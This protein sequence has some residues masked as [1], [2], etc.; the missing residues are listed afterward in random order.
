M[1]TNKLCKACGNGDVALVE[2]L[3]ESGATPNFASC[4]NG[5]RYPL[6]YAA[7]RGDVEIVKL[8]LQNEAAVDPQE[9][10]NAWTPLMVAALKSVNS[11][12]HATVILTLIQAG[13]DVEI[14][15]EK[16]NTVVHILASLGQTELLK[17]LLEE[18]PSLDLIGPGFGY[19]TP[20]H[21]AA[22]AGHA[23]TVEFLLQQ[24]AD[25]RG[26]DATGWTPLHWACRKGN[27]QGDKDSVSAGEAAEFKRRRL[28]GNRRVFLRWALASMI[29]FLSVYDYASRVNLAALGAAVAHKTQS[30]GPILFAAVVLA[31]ASVVLPSVALWICCFSHL[32]N[33]WAWAGWKAAGVVR[34][35]ANSAKRDE[36]EDVSQGVLALSELRVLRKLAELRRLACSSSSSL[37]ARLAIGGVVLPLAAFVSSLVVC[38]QVTAVL[39]AATLVIVIMCAY[40]SF[41]LLATKSLLGF[42]GGLLHLL[43]TLTYGSALK[44]V[45]TSRREKNIELD[46]K[47]AFPSSCP[48]GEEQ[49]LQ[50][51]RRQTEDLHASN[52]PNPS[53]LPPPSECHQGLQII[54]EDAAAGE[55]GSLSRE[56]A[57]RVV[58]DDEAAAPQ[59]EGTPR[60]KGNAHVKPHCSVSIAPSYRKATYS[61]SVPRAL[62]PCIC[63]SGAIRLHHQHIRSSR[64]RNR[65][66]TDYEKEDDVQSSSDFC[67]KSDD[68]R[69]GHTKKQAGLSAAGSGWRFHGSSAG[70][71]ADSVRPTVAGHTASAEICEE[72]KRKYW[73]SGLEA[74]SIV[75]LSSKEDSAG[76]GLPSDG[77]A[78]SSDEYGL[79]SFAYGGWPRHAG[80]AE[81]EVQGSSNT[82]DQ[83][84]G[85]FKRVTTPSVRA[86]SVASL[87]AGA[88]PFRW[89][90]GHTAQQSGTTACP[91]PSPSLRTHAI[92]ISRPGIPAA[93]GKNEGP[94]SSP[95][96]RDCHN[97]LSSSPSSAGPQHRWLG[98]KL[99][100][101]ANETQAAA[102]NSEDATQ[103]HHGESALVPQPK[104]CIFKSR[105]Q[106]P[107]A[108]ELDSAE[109]RDL[110]LRR[111][112]RIF[113][114]F[115][116]VVAVRYLEVRR[117]TQATMSKELDSEDASYRFEEVPIE[118]APP[119]TSRSVSNVNEKESIRW[120]NF[121]TLFPPGPSAHREE[122]SSS[123]VATGKPPD[124]QV[125]SCVLTEDLFFMSVADPTP[126]SWLIQS[127]KRCQKKQRAPPSCGSVGDKPIGDSL[128]TT[129]PHKVAEQC[130][131]G[132]E[133]SSI[134]GDTS[135]EALGLPVLHYRFNDMV[136]MPH[137]REAFFTF[138][139]REFKKL[140][141]YQDQYFGDNP[142]W[143]GN[144]L[145]EDSISAFSQE[146]LF[147][148]ISTANCSSFSD[149]QLPSKEEL[150][151]KS[152]LP[153]EVHWFIPQKTRD[154]NEPCKAQSVTDEHSGCGVCME[155]FEG[156]TGICVC[157]GLPEPPMTYAIGIDLAELGNSRS[158]SCLKDKFRLLDKQRDP[159]PADAEAAPPKP[160]CQPSPATSIFSEN[161]EAVEAMHSPIGGS[162]KLTQGG[163]PVSEACRFMFAL[164]LTTDLLLGLLPLFGSLLLIYFLPQKGI[165]P[166]SPGDCADLVPG[167]FSVPGGYLVSPQS[168]TTTAA[169][170]ALHHTSFWSIFLALLAFFTHAALLSS[171]AT[172]FFF[173][174]SNTRVVPVTVL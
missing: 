53:R 167:L 35:F 15:D 31:S 133:G 161:M 135:S 94:A 38:M 127:G 82:C 40:I 134:C 168:M 88:S 37:V 172:D 43:D 116:Q 130:S 169:L 125:L 60:L 28:E 166:S 105:R 65:L 143:I 156:P 170:C 67:D 11:P 58:V 10:S 110:M 85:V 158:L 102:L 123:V 89:L 91:Q 139:S 55:S 101:T 83:T 81:G 70:L 71:F 63:L 141:I 46:T 119:S 136:E 155:R 5:Y 42:P 145:E 18:V 108:V 12:S 32:K 4:G 171:Q 21:Y 51:P 30:A 44:L 124:P 113:K 86:E 132:T 64:R 8:L 115:E 52:Q 66:A 146:H 25:P 140:L 61:G 7:D 153:K 90:R 80:Q 164:A 95:F 13:A 49:Q 162:G 109:Y 93:S 57:C 118:P 112:Q 131:G 121:Q 50:E 45:A 107:A 173:P 96:D 2:Q 68:S 151:L 147:S 129:S 56:R 100:F 19:L 59:G 36:R 77:A 72:A 149:P 39:V 122:K 144:V 120:S 76:E 137:L 33:T 29:V 62:H 111:E 157:Q 163:L 174:M 41:G 92:R 26:I 106:K 87:L 6:H 84:E 150:Q 160:Y 138:W 24:G 47:T 98:L 23:D 75:N 117:L 1:L 148:S 9:S 152:H 16:G 165:D 14:T 103:K 17:Q 74:G 69:A 99:V 79:L 48:T 128:K 104:I 97:T 22:E 34:L 73:S 27:K 126:R 142:L 3:L 78:A 159:E 20:L 54:S 114:W 154:L